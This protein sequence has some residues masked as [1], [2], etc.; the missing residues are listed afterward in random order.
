M[1]RD[2]PRTKGIL[3]A[4]VLSVTAF[5]LA[6]LPQAA[7]LQTGVTA[8]R[9]GRLI[10]PDTGTVSTDQI[11]LIEGGQIVAVGTNLAIPTGATVIKIVVDDQRYIYSVDAITFIKAEAAGAGVQD[12]HDAGVRDRCHRSR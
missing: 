4:L 5:A 6:P 12:C 3:I 2:M 9:A 7:P 1:F 10:D 8:T 11:I